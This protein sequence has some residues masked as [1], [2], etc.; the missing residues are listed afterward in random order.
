MLSISGSLFA[1][2]TVK[3]ILTQG[4]TF[5]IAAFASLWD[6]GIYA[7]ASGYGGLLARIVFQPIEES[8]R[9]LFAKVLSQDQGDKPEPGNL[10]SAHKILTRIIRVYL[11]L[12]IV[13]TA[14]GPT[15]AP[16]LL[17]I[18]AGSRWSSS[19][20]GQVLA[21]YCYYIPL[22]ALNG[23]TEAFVSAVATTAQL[24]LQ[25]LWMFA[26]STGFAGAAYLF[27]EVLDWGAEGLVWANAINMLFRILWSGSFI[28]RYF[29][30]HHTTTTVDWS[31]VIVDV[32]PR[33]ATFTL[34]VLVAAVC[35]QIQAPSGMTSAKDLATPAFMVLSTLVML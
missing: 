21:T 8:S 17:R 30:R 2:S 16:F 14:L 7:F 4:D 26:F 5:L 32:L 1:Q 23:V 25:S 27:V 12:G 6:Q 9:N 35:R 22:L 10:R 11:L 15:Y 29:R 28:T 20:A 24:N 34:G 31:V 18:V 19:R 13:A 33:P 3:H